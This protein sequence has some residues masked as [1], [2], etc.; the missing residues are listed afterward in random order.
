MRTRDDMAIVLVNRSA[1]ARTVNVPTAAVVRD[2]VDFVP[3][4]GR[5]AAAAAIEG[6]RLAA[7]IPAMTA[8]V[9]VARPGQRITPRPAPHRLGRGRRRRVVPDLAQPAGRP[10]S[11]NLG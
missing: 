9:L 1:A 8:Q 10:L 6:G 3:T 11:V 2:G 5:E 4:L 7:R